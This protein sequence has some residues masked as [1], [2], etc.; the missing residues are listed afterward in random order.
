MIAF[1]RG[2]VGDGFDAGAKASLDR[3]DAAVEIEGDRL[4]RGSSQRRDH[5]GQLV[6][7]G[8]QVDVAF[9]GIVKQRGQ[10]LD[11]AIDRA[12]RAGVGGVLHAGADRAEV[13]LIDELRV[14]QGQFGPCGAGFT[15]LCFEDGSKAGVP[16]AVDRAEEAQVELWLVGEGSAGRLDRRGRKRSVSRC[17][18]VGR[19]EPGETS[20]GSSWPAK[21]A[22]QDAARPLA[23]PP[24]GDLL[25]TQSAD[26]PTTVSR[27]KSH[28]SP[29]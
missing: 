10:H 28:Q 21:G 19:P 13:G 11:V 6:G 2:S 8:A 3:V 22:G 18:S 23:W 5:V 4:A 26:A 15:G 12:C 7:G 14:R 16:A 24:S 20:W 1:F 9:Q 29:V 17:G 27:S 25:V